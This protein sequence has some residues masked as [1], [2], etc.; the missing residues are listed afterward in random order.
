MNTTD[1]RL[2][3]T[4]APSRNALRERTLPGHEANP[5]ARPDVPALLGREG[6]R[7]DFN[8]GCR[9]QVPVAGWRVRMRDL[10]TNNVISLDTFEAGEIA[11]SRRKYFVRFQFDVFDGARVVFSH[12]FDATW[13][14]VLIE[15]GSGALGDAI[16]WMPAIEAFRQQHECQVTVQ[17]RPGLRPLFEDAYPALQFVD[18][19]PGEIEAEGEPFYAS[20]RLDRYLPYTDRD[21]QPTDAR[22]S[23]QQDFAS[24]MLGVP[25]IER[26]P[27]IVVANRERTIRE[28]YVC[29]GTQASAQCKYWNN[30]GGWPALIALLRACG[31]RVLCIDRDREHGLA[32]ALNTI[33]EGAEDFTGDR[34][35]T[36]RASLLAHADFFIGVAGGLS[37]LAWAVR[38]PVVLISGHSHPKAEF[39]TPWRVINFR[40]CNSCYNDTTVEFDSS[41]FA[42]CPRHAGDDRRFEC[43]SAITPEQVMGVIGPLISSGGQ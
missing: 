19:L 30:A 27:N 11:S 14:R 12:A 29:I 1:R 28:R 33:P 41:D 3:A 21:H 22:V 2:T 9:V 35:L 16:A 18:G 8:Y 20:Y 6:V 36:E 10:D 39:H 40:V 17:L 25:A 24:Y 26:R 42:W 34:P 4:P 37:W 13:R 5:S 23:N 31:Y 32:G 7:Y 38:T 43:T 15:V